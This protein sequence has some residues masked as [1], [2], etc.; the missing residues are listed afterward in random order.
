MLER[1]KLLAKHSHEKRLLRHVAITMHGIEQNGKPDA[2]RQAFR[3]VNELI[4]IQLNQD[5]PIMSLYLLPEDDR[6][7]EHFLEFVDE[8]ALFFNSL[9]DDK[10]IHEKKVKISALGKWYDLPSK[11]VEAIKSVLH[12]TKDYDMFFLNF[13]IN[14]DGQEEIVDAC[15]LIARQVSAAKLDAEKISKE[16][17]KDNLYSSYFLP[18]CLLIKNGKQR[19][20]SGMLLWDSG[21]AELHF[22]NKDF[23]D[24]TKA[25]FEKVVEQFKRG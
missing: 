8:F 24:F 9:K 2:Y 3:T 7:K 6:K 12:E 20:T 22:T 13:C 17:I 10:R 5:I 23:S 4:D 19:S 15:R 21:S 11:A 1:F 25:D 18:P 16:V 14:Y